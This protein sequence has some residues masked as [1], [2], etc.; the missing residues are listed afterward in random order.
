[1]LSGSGPFIWVPYRTTGKG[2]VMEY[3]VRTLLHASFPAGGIKPG[4]TVD[5]PVSSID[6]VPTIFEFAGPSAY[7]GSHDH[8]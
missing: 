7:K 4:T 1:M 5:L 2:T 8:Y 3:G 6:L